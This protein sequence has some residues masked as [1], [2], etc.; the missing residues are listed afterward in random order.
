MEKNLKS[1]CN[2]GDPAL[3]P[4]WGRSPGEGN[5]DPTPVFLPGESH[6][7]RSLAGHSPWSCKELD[8]AAKPP[9]IKLNHLA[10][11][12]KHCKWTIL[13]FFLKEKVGEHN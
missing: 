1:T 9:Y 12:L 8:L 5:G 6:G 7:Q 3:I 10:V 11:Y 4:G 13:Q 2:A